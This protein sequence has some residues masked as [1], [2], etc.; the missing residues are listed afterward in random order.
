MCEEVLKA[1]S[2]LA[3]L[4]LVPPLRLSVRM[5]VRHIY[6]MGRVFRSKDAK[7]FY[8]QPLPL[9]TR[10]FRPLMHACALPGRSF[11][12]CLKCN[13]PIS[14]HLRP[15]R[16]VGRS[17]IISFKGGKLHFHVPIRAL[18]YVS[19]QIMM[20]FAKVLLNHLYSLRTQIS[21]NSFFFGLLLFCLSLSACLSVRLGWSVCHDLLCSLI[22]IEAL[23]IFSDQLL[24][25][26]R[27]FECEE[28]APAF[29]NFNEK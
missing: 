20:R 8:I 1:T 22:P 21:G 23:V 5:R 12:P 3:I 4:I 25:K 15:L 17:V 9:Y 26:L 19:V 18:V 7:H 16:L 29:S 2:Y 11:E 27:Q 13:F 10:P 6:S 24:S 14:S 28:Q